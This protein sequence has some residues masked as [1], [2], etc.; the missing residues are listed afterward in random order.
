MKNLIIV[1]AFLFSQLINAQSKNTNKILL[2][3][4]IPEQVEG[5]PS[6][7]KRLF[8]N[9]LGQIITKN[10]IS[11]NVANSRFII[12]PNVSVLSKNILATAPTKVALNLEVTLYVGDGIAGNLFASESFNLKGVGTNE[13]KAYI[14]ALR[15]LKPSHKSVQELLKRSKEKILNYYNANC[16]L[17]VKKAEGFI[18]RNQMSQALATYAKVPEGSSCFDKVKIQMASIY[19]KAINED[20]KR[21]LNQ[22][23]GIWSA[24]QDIAAANEVGKLL[25]QVEPNANCF[26]DVKNLYNQVATR[27][28]DLQDRNWNYQLKKLDLTKSN[29]DAAKAIGV[30][31]GN[32]QPNNVTYN[33][34]GWF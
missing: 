19:L 2:G 12:T 34:R 24:N 18:A 5:I 4:Y 26:A 20:C 1:I 7:A 21:L 32:N 22:A 25:A 9:K 30:A 8:I 15:T 33:T 13:N 17:L 27:V 3:A 11:D 14:A 31:Y 29:I 16:D 28:K 23:Q 10:G 6:S